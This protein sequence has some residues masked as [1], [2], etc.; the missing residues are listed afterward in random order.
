MDKSISQKVLEKIKEE[1]IAP[2]PEWRFSVCRIF[3]LALLGFF[4]V[5][6]AISLGIIFDLFSQFEIQRL[7]GRPKGMKL[8]F[9]SLPYILI[10]LL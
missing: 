10:F 8:I 7:F 2:K 6:G 1:K 4:L 3:V 5:A 9:I